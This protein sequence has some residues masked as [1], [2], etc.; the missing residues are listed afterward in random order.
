MSNDLIRR[1]IVAI[2]DHMTELTLALHKRGIDPNQRED[3]EA[4]EVVKRI[5]E[6]AYTR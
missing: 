1:Q 3:R 2:M 4:K 5:I 6:R